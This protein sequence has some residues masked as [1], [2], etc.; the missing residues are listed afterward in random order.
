[1]P[2]RFINN[3]IREFMQFEK[4]LLGRW[5]L[6]N[7]RMTKRKIEMANTDHCG[8]CTYMTNAHTNKEVKDRKNQTAVIVKEF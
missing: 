4:T 2:F 5:E 6:N 8:T 3:M 1:M 7:I